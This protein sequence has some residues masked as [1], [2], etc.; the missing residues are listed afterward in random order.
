MYMY[1]Y[2]L[3]CIFYLLSFIFYLLPFIFC[4]Q[5]KKKET[6]TTNKGTNKGEK[7]TRH[8]T[9]DGE[10]KHGKN[11]ETKGR[12]AKQVQLSMASYMFLYVST[13]SDIVMY[14][15][16]AFYMYICF[17][18]FLYG[19]QYVHVCSD[20]FLYGSYMFIDCHMCL[21]RQTKTQEQQTLKNCETKERK[22]KQVCVSICSYM[23]LYVLYSH[24]LSYMF[25]QCSICIYV[26]ICFYVCSYSF[27]YCHIMFLYGFHI[28]S[29]LVI[30]A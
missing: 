14:V 30:Y 17:P 16:I 26:F 18:M 23:F 8:N 20:M 11:C 7:E 10:N 15:P 24:I 4:L 19:F 9:E 12:K 3:C 13:F 2:M 29:Y 28:C 1:M 21:M 22:A 27:I 6:R 25:L 5:T